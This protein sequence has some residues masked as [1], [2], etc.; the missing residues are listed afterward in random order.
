ML[1]PTW[2]TPTPATPAPP[3]RTIST[4]AA[5]W[6]PPV[7]TSEWVHSPYPLSP[8]PPA[9]VSAGRPAPSLMRCWP[10]GVAFSFRR[11]LLPVLG[12]QAERG[13][14]RGSERSPASRSPPPL[15][16][17]CG[18]APSPGRWGEALALVPPALPGRARLRGAGEPWWSPSCALRAFGNLSG[19]PARFNPA[20]LRV[21]RDMKTSTAL[22]WHLYI[23]RN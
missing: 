13:S 19:S 20:F 8:L 2:P 10:L 22:I 16:G 18:R 21:E 17:L 11:Q 14:P 3:S 5:A 6:P 9:P 15:P 12:S 1:L 23:K 7:C 4:M